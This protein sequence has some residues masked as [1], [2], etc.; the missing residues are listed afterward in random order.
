MQKIFLILG[1]LLATSLYTSAQTTA[2]TAAQRTE[3]ADH[4]W[5]APAGGLAGGD[6]GRS[7]AGWGDSS[8]RIHFVFQQKDRA[9][10]LL[11]RR[12]VVFDETGGRC[13]QQGRAAQCLAAID[14]ARAVRG[15]GHGSG[16]KDAGA[17]RWR[18]TK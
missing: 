14:G 16:R 7:R 12:E 3:K 8:R 6:Q 2:Q 11:E 17:A 10:E 9:G 5:L 4:P 18:D 15:G 1:L 13:H